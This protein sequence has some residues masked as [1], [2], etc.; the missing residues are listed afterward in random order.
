MVSEI[1]EAKLLMGK[2]KNKYPD[3]DT[4]EVEYGGS[5]DDGGI[6]YI[7]GNII[8][9]PSKAV[10]LVYRDAL[11]EDIRDFTD[12]LIDNRHAG[13]YNN[14]GGGGTVTYFLRKEK[15]TINHHWYEITTVQVKEE[16]IT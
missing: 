14:E 9:K 3:Y 6:Q 1:E 13:Y 12:R 2:I 4:I 10:M 15:V 16:E 5:G 7:S 11:Y 8:G